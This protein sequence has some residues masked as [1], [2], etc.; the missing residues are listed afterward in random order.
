MW[1]LLERVKTKI[2]TVEF[3]KLQIGR[4]EFSFPIND[5]LLDE[6]EYSPIKKANATCHLE[7]I[8]SDSMY[9]LVFKIEGLASASCDVCLDEFDLSLNNESNLLIKLTDGITNID[10]DEIIFLPKALHEFDFKQFIYEFFLLAIPSKISCEDANKEHN[11]AFI[12][13]LSDTEIE[14]DTENIDPR[15]AAL[16]N[17]NNKN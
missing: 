13:K 16:K 10:D 8:K 9:D 15:W 2:Y 5:S 11:Q 1:A 17:L 3:N 14:D 6:F 4:N 12:D 7:L